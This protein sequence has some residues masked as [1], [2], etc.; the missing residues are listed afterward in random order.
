MN[1]ARETLPLRELIEVLQSLC[2]ERR[3]GTMYLHTD[4]N[5][6][7]RI[8][9]DRGR[10]FFIAYGRYRGMGAIEQF[11]RMQ[12][13]KFSFAES[14]FNNASETPLPLT[15]ELLTQLNWAAIGD[16]R[17]SGETAEPL[18]GL[19][20]LPLADSQASTLSVDPPSAACF[21]GIPLPVSPP[22][23]DDSHEAL[24]LTGARLYEAVAGVLAL[25]IGPVASAVCEDY[26][27]QLVRLATAAEFRAV[28]AQIATEA[29][30]DGEA[31]RFMARVLAK[32][33][34]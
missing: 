34:L 9:M 20:A 11:K 12:F 6:S 23:R 16:P 4:T 18:R 8:S 30:S 15:G 14:I 7:A 5:H 32:A 21:A 31:A 10:I 24:R 2:L 3:T 19:S 33:G 28:T 29:G 27:E 25:S 13:G 22:D 1:Q 17:A 26:R